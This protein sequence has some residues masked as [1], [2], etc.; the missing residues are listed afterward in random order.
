MFTDE[1]INIIGGALEEK[2]LSH[3]QIDE[4]FL[5][6]YGVKGMKWGQRRHLNIQKRID[7]QRRVATGT[8]SRGDKLASG[9][10]AIN[11]NPI[12]VVKRGFSGTAERNVMKA[13]ELQ[14][15]VANGEA[16][17]TKMLLKLSGVK[18]E[19]LNYDL[20]A[21]PSTFA[22]TAKGSSVRD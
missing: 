16:K 6:H 14:T 17:V 3:S 11:A 7:M 22:K 18:I 10:N 2:G 4:H 21:N 15:K 19:K 13:A 5:E 8:G 20:D 9:Y 12:S 1:E